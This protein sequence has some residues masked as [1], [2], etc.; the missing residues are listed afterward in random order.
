MLKNQPEDNCS[1]L[2]KVTVAAPCPANWEDM[3]GDE[4]ERFCGQCSLN[5][6]NISTM[7][8]D[9]AEEF[10]ALRTEGRSCVRFYQRKDGTIITDNCPKALRAIRK[11]SKKVVSAVNLCL[12]FLLGAQS[13]SWAQRPNATAGGMK[14]HGGKDTQVVPHDDHEGQVLDHGELEFDESPETAPFGSTLTSRTPTAPPPPIAKRTGGGEWKIVDQN[15][16]TLMTYAV[17]HPGNDTKFPY[18]KRLSALIGALGVT[19]IESL[20]EPQENEE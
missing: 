12:V 10:L 1:L 20:E 18:V 2:S 13:A 9:E 6:Y 11:A 15:G 16:N 3:V 14:F 5:V 4:R 8:R 7:S 19:I 17:R